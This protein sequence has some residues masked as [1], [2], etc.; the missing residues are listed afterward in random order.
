MAPSLPAR[1]Q[2]AL[3]GT[4]GIPEA[5]SVEDFIQPIDASEEEGREVL[6]VREDEDGVSMALHLPRA[7]LE[8][9]SPPFDLLCQVVEGVS[10][11]LCLAERARR[12]LPVTQLEL[13]LQAEVDKYVLFVHGPLA[14]R[15]FDPSRAARIRARLFE[16]V[17]YLHPPGTERGD[18]YRLAND[19]AARFAGRLEESFA[20]R[21]HFDRMRRALRSFYAA[22]QSDKISL[23]RAA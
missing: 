15:R 6:F 1:I 4:Y 7:A 10:H 5:P 14:A 17:A 16:A 20:R 21:G 13:E 3:E 2:A 11:F 18:R 9:K 22:G 8:P 12:E 19:L 23:A